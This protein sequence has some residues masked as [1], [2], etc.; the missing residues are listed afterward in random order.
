MVS[1]LAFLTELLASVVDLVV[2]FVTDVLL[3]DPLGAISLLV[4]GALTTGTLGFVT[5]LAIGAVLDLFGLTLPTP[6]RTSP[7]VRNRDDRR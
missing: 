7:T 1:L 4:G 2:I 6:G 5:Y 3:V